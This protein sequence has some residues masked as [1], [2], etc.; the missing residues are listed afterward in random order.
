MTF[1]IEPMLTLGTIDYDDLGRRLDGRHRGP[2]AHGAVRA[3]PARHRDGCRDPDAPLKPG[4]PGSRLRAW[5]SPRAGRATVKTLAID[6]GGTGLKASVLGPATGDM[7]VDR[8]RVDTPYPCRPSSSVSSLLELVEPLPAF[9]RVSVGFPGLIRRG[10]VV[11]VPSLSRRRPAARASTRAWRQLCGGL[12]AGD[13]LRKAFGKPAPPGQRRRRAGLRGRLG[14]GLRVRADPGHRAGLR[15][16]QGRPSCSPTSSCRT[17]RSGTASPSTIS[18][19]TPR[20]RHRPSA[21]TP[22]FHK[23]LFWISDVLYPD[24]IYIGGGNAKRL[25]LDPGPNVGSWSN[26]AGIL[27]GIKLWERHESIRHATPSS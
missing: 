25:D 11:M 26:R 16:V 21:G 18:S 23:A 3:H 14:R 22:A 13:P 20:A 17:G 5:R 27:G 12:S 24:R 19:A 9:H 1:T 4:A 6:V 7:L 15:A 2:Q 8:V 10:H